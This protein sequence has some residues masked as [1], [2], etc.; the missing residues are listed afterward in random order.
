[1]CAR[2]VGIEQI[3]EYDP[4]HVV[5]HGNAEQMK[6]RWRDIECACPADAS[7]LAKR[8]ARCQ[9]ESIHGVVSRMA[10]R[11]ADFLDGNVN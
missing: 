8:R 5:R 6:D 9:E 11:G 10:F 4:F 3:L 2:P 1:M 7:P